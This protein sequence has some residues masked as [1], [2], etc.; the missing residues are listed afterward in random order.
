M[1]PVLFI[2][3]SPYLAH[4]NFEQ[5]SIFLKQKL[6]ENSYHSIAGNMEIAGTPN[7]SSIMILKGI[8]HLILTA[9]SGD[10]GIEM[11]VVLPYVKF[12]TSLRQAQTCLP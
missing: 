6:S 8:L 12:I 3:F 10:C 11:V 1:I 2:I 7:L 4:A 5:D 9:F